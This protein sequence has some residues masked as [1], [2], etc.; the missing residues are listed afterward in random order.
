M[1]PASDS[2]AMRPA[3]SGLSN[4]TFQLSGFAFTFDLR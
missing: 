4:R 1:S 3:Y 2:Q